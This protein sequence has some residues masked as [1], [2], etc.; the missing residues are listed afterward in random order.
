TLIYRDAVN[1]RDER[2]DDLNLR[3]VAESLS[4]PFAAKGSLRAFGIEAAFE[5]TLGRLVEEG[6]TPF[7]VVVKP[8]DETARLQVSGA[9][10][11]HPG[12]TAVNGRLKGE[13]QN[14]ARLMESLTGRG[15][16]PSALAQ[17]VSIQGEISVDQRIATV[18]NLGLELGGFRFAGGMTTKFRP[19][20]D[21]RIT[22]SAAQLDLDG[23][24]TVGPSDLGAEG[25][26]G[27]T[28]ADGQ[29]AENVWVLPA[30][31]NA[32]LEV[33]VEALIYR[34][35]LIRQLRVD[36]GLGD[37]ELQL[38]RATALLPGSSDISLTGRFGEADGEAQFDGH[39]EAASDNLRGL[40]QWAGADLGA[41][42]SDRLRRMSVSGRV[43]GSP[44]QIAISELDLRVDLSRL[45]GGLVIAPRQRPGF[46]VGL[47][48]DTINLDAYL[49][50]AAARKP[51]TVASDGEQAGDDGEGA[52]DGLALLDRFD[53]NLNL[54]AGSVTLRGA[55][56]KDLQV[57]ATLQGGVLE[58]RTARIGNLAG[59]EISYIGRVDKVASEP[60]LDGGLEISIGEPVRLASLLGLDPDAFAKVPALSGE[61]RITGRLEDLALE[62]RVTG[63]GGRL[64]IAGALRP[65]AR[66][67]AVDL[68]L[69]GRHP[70][71][72]ALLEMAGRPLPAGSDL[73]VVDL[74]LRVAGDS[75]RFRIS[76]LKGAFG[77]ARLSGGFDLALDGTGPA[78]SNL[79]VGIDAAY[80]DAGQLAGL[81]G[82]IE[83]PPAGLG[84]LEFKT[85]LNGG[86]TQARL[87]ELQ[88]NIGPIQLAGSV[89]LDLNGLAPALESYDVSVA[90]KHP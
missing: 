81:A 89:G 44:K 80:A 70:S 43:T 5:A 57:E 42:P 2:F 21:A 32:R 76:E 33:S 71:F 38:E 3:I 11:T 68:R 16:W 6:A 56:A 61:G 20:F 28:A 24:L 74:A 85:R 12:T 62:A 41:V 72:A 13:G 45:S 15:S 37:G 46:G 88:A 82:L 8:V 60:E 7:N 17:P 35:Q 26:T 54:R 58:F 55:T 66:P 39:L 31:A 69:T 19:P 78:I 30:D 87:D 14:L 67:P 47:A 63:A 29:E 84:S 49:P 83:P 59:G 40:L 79:D 4:G 51:Q 36:A 48:L 52:G 75:G 50:S 9:I 10:S 18:S 86:P 27:A 73:G 25:E 22:L 65:A 53:A 34:G 77:P 64:E 23:L 1:G 90:A